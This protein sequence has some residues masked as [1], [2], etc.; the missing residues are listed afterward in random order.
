MTGICFTSL[1]TDE[2]GKNGQID[3]AEIHAAATPDPLL[4]A[5]A[6]RVAELWLLNGIGAS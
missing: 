1:G 2:N 6:G 4:G 5:C 3:L